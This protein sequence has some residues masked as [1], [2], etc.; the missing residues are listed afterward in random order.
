MKKLTWIKIK[1]LAKDNSLVLFV[2]F[3]WFVFGF[4]MYRFALRMS[5]VE[6]L[7]ASLFFRDNSSRFT[8]FYEMWT[9]G[10]IFGVTF[11]VPFENVLMRYNPDR[12]C[13]M[14]AKAMK[15]H[16]VVVGFSHLG[17][18]LVAHF[19]EHNVPYC[20]IERDMER[21]DD[22]LRGGEPVVVDDARETDALED[23]NVAGAKAVLIVSNNLE[24][25]LLVTKR[26]HEANPACTIVARCYQDEFAEILEG[27]GASEV[28]SS[29][30]NA[31]D[32]IV[33]RMDA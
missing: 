24:T 26:V 20:V 17:R 27:L 16:M 30:K 11:S 10:V 13:R 7:E 19:R 25:A 23:A 28:I 12:S 29:S 33:S 21:V 32:D 14:L 4:L 2:L 1:L 9:Q 3:L 15:D 5:V 6:A 18:R 31:F 8:T 22:L